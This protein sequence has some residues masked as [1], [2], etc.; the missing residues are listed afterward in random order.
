M[1]IIITT[2]SSDLY[3]KLHY[4]LILGES[5]SIPAT[6]QPN[7]GYTKVRIF[8]ENTLHMEPLAHYYNN[9]QHM[10]NER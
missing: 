7:L 6:W 1:C 2:Y 8:V 9:S 5:R 10:I 3:L 4:T